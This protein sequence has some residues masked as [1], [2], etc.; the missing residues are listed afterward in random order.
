MPLPSMGR[1]GLT[2][3]AG[4]CLI[5]AFVFVVMVAVWFVLVY[6]V[7]LV[8]LVRWFSVLVCVGRCHV[9]GGDDAISHCGT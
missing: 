9:G 1:W 5:P 7:W 4:A 2:N 3:E 6:G 8:C